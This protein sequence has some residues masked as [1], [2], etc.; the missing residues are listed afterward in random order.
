MFNSIFNLNQQHVEKKWCQLVSKIDAKHRIASVAV[1]LLP[2]GSC[3]APTVLQ[4]FIR[5]SLETKLLP[6]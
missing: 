1:V 4:M 2:E 5:K 6:I 3:S